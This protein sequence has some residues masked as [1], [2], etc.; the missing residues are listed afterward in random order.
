M[1]HIARAILDRLPRNRRG[2]YAFAWLH[3]VKKHRRLPQD[4]SVR[5]N[6]LLFFLKTGDEA[7]NPL[8]A[9]VTD[10][11][12]VKLFVAAEVGPE[13]VVPSLAVLRSL[14]EAEVFP[15]PPDCV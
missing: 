4:K 2:D 8:R 3:F 10:K 13:Y 9:F 1:M 11:E 15:F 14:E 7:L 5:F 6:D 12:L